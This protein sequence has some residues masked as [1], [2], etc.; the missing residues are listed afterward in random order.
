MK[1]STRSLVLNSTLAGLLVIFA[2]G[3]NKPADTSGTAPPTTTVGMEIDDSVLTA[4]VKSALL[5]DPDVKSVDFKVETR[6][7]E[8]LLSGFV[9]SQAQ[10]DRA[11]AVAKGVSGVK[12]VLNNATIK[13]STIT[14][15]NT[16]DD[17]V[18]TSRVK[19]A[20]LGDES[21]KSR[22]IAIVTRKGEVQLSGF[23]DNQQQIDRA[24]EI[25]RGIQDVSGVSNEM[26]IKK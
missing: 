20:L 9:D 23:V 5:A 4:S 2:A 11:N 26:S 21:T 10:I 6:K 15:G 25:T 7:G 24:I 12:N 18:V 14:V 13:E 16:V 1:S 17:S 8:V 3:C 19:T 22:D